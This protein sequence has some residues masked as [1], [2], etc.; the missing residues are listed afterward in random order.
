VTAGERLERRVNLAFWRLVN[1][2]MRGLAG[3][4]PWW[5]VLETTGRR[6][7]Q[8]RR[9]PLARGPMDG[10]VTWLISVHGSHAAF[11]R[12]IAANPPVRLK[13]GGSWRDGTA[14]LMPTT[15]PC[16][17][18]ST[19][20]RAWARARPESIPNWSGSSYPTDDEPVREAELAGTVFGHVSGTSAV[21][22]S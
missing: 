10:S 7:G 4:A 9:V 20:M 15:K 1:L 13:I 19:P 5:V 16:S 18:G 22:T 8:P 14:E 2:P 6:T 12:N 21:S 17:A 11:A 3:I